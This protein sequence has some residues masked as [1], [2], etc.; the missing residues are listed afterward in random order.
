MKLKR[1]SRG[2]STICCSRRKP[3]IAAFRS[4]RGA[5]QHAV[6]DQDRRLPGGLRLLPAKRK[7]DTGL[8]RERLLPLDEVREAAM[9]AKQN[10]ATRFCMGAAWRNPT[11][12]NLD[13]VIEMIRRS[14]SSGMETC[15]T[16]GMLTREQSAA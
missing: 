7:Y 12:K 2:L 16:L 10:G 11:D 15:V 4:Q 14:R 3:C 13:K 6:V 9:N 1:F 8:E 5:D